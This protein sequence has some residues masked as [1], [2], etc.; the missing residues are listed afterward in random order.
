MEE[1]LNQITIDIGNAFV[2]REKEIFLEAL[3]IKKKSK[4][5]RS[6]ENDEMEI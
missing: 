4:I 2:E 1:S 5:R 3:H 6:R